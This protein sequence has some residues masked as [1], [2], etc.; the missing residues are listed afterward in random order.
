MIQQ[1]TT[2]LIQTLMNEVNTPG[3]LSAFLGKHFSLI[4]LISK[5]ER[6]AIINAGK[7]LIPKDKDGKLLIPENMDVYEFLR[8]LSPK[9]HP[10]K[11]TIAN[12]MGSMLSSYMGSIKFKP[13][14]MESDERNFVKTILSSKLFGI[15]DLSNFEVE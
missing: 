5:E 1:E 15:D 6:I 12:M 8:A 10:Y 7:P 11:G 14:D 9:L 3:M 2:A 4:S 13:E